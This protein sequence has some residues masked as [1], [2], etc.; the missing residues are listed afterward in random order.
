MRTWTFDCSGT[1]RSHVLHCCITENI[2]AIICTIDIRI[3]MVTVRCLPWCSDQHFLAVQQLADSGYG[4]V[5]L[6][7]HLLSSE[8]TSASGPHNNTD[9]HCMH[10]RHQCHLQCATVLHK[11]NQLDRMSGRWIFVLCFR[12]TIA[13]ISPS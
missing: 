2:Q 1:V 9:R 4:S 12:W 3:S 6:H 8:G 5:T 10:I 13:C 11:D 7:R